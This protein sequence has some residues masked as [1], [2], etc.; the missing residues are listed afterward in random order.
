[1]AESKEDKMSANAAELQAIYP[2]NLELEHVE[3]V[4]FLFEPQ[5]RRR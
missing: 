4:G 3:L 5:C 2:E 1:M